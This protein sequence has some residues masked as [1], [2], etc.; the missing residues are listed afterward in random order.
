MRPLLE[1]LSSEF[2]NDFPF[3]LLGA[4]TSDR[5]T[6]TWMVALDY[7][8]NWIR[9]S[10]AFAEAPEFDYVGTK[11]P[12]ERLNTTVMNAEV[13]NRLVSFMNNLKADAKTLAAIIAQRQK[14]PEAKFAN[15]KESFPIIIASIGASTS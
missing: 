13:D 5:L 11:S 12:L 2:A 7:L 14:F 6:Q 3:S 10:Q 9:T 4:D 15:V 8:R 1:A